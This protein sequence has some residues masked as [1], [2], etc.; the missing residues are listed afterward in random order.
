[1]SDKNDLVGVLLA[2]GKGL[3]SY[4]STKFI[5]KPLFKVDSETLLLKNI[6]ILT[7]ELKVKEIFI[8]IGHLSEY[9]ISYVNNLTLTIKISFVIQ[10][11][12]NGIANG[13]YLLKKN[14]D[15]KRFIVIL[16]DEY[17]HKPNHQDLL[18]KISNGYSSILTF[19]N[20]P[21]LKIVSKNFIGQFEFDKVIELEE[22]PK[23]PST[24]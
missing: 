23:N 17:Y 10:K 14:L 3:R 9:I 18:N 1:M 21:N 6:R 22:K 11:E 12:I 15:K 2:G 5:P 19:I 7:D 4:P 16:A 24:S 8:V 20:E 13:L